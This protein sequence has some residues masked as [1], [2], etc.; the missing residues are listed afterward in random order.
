ME[1]DHI[2]NITPYKHINDVL[3]SLTKGILELLEDKVIGIYL[4]GSLSYVDFIPERSDIDLLVITRGFLSQEELEQI[5][6][7]HLI[8]EE[9]F[10]EWKDRIECSYTPL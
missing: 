4:F 1:F 6:Q 10:K 8:I 3:Y 9:N 7:F 5:K 2:K